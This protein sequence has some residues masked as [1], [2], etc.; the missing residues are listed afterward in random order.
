MQYGRPF[1]ISEKEVLMAKLNNKKKRLIKNE[2]KDFTF[3]LPSLVIF[4]IIIIIPLLS[5]IR[6]TFTDWNGMAK[7][8]NFVGLKNYITVFTDKD[9]LL[10][11]R[12]TAIFTLVTTFVINA[13]GLGL[14]M[15][16]EKE[17]KGVNIIKSIVFI[18]LVVSL[19]LVFY[20]WMYVYSDFFGMLG[21]NSPLI[22]KKTVL[23]GLCVMAIWKEVGLAMMI[24]LAALKG[25]SSDYYEAATIDG[26]GFW[27]K[28]RH[29]TVPMIAPAFTYCIPLW[30]AGGLRMY[31]YSYVATAGGPNHASESM[32]YYIYQYLFPF[33]KV[34]YGQTVALIYLVFCIILSNVITRMLRK[35]EIEL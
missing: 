9:L 4:I 22:S 25:V 34:G 30:I 15:M 21:L 1:F 35:R 31:D 23:M 33:N 8:M 29:V 19:V 12:N 17:F 18:P 16:V 28:F 11:I 6:Y 2:I 32:A 13:L 20:M 7:T 5:G 3:V 27:A 10:P 14:A 26:A 24:Y